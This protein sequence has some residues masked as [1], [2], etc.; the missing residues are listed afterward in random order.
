MEIIARKI[1]LIYTIRVPGSRFKGSGF[2]VL[3]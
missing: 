3:G 1:V 2:E